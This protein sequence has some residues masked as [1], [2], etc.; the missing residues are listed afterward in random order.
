M[1]LDKA[2]IALVGS[3]AATFV[4]GVELR[5]AVSR[6]E[7]TTQDLRERVVRIEHDL[8]SRR[9]VSSFDPDA[10]EPNEEDSR[11]PGD[12]RQ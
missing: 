5:L 4:G 6:V 7:T 10:S 3:L 1:K 11:S 12:S 8:D 9:R 2:T